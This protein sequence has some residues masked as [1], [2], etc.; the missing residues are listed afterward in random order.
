MLVLALKIGLQNLAGWGFI[1]LHDT[2]LAI[3]IRV[4]VN[5]DRIDFE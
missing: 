1:G 3:N 4:G 5:E 2:R